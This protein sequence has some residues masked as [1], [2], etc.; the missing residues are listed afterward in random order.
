MARGDIYSAIIVDLGRILSGFQWLEEACY[1]FYLHVVNV[2]TRK[3]MYV[4]K[5]KIPN[6]SELFF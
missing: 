4:K 6:A 2:E 3:L 5:F 1:P